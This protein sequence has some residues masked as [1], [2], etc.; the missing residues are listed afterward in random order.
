MVWVLVGIRVGVRLRVGEGKCRV[1]GRNCCR[2][3]AM[4]MGAGRFKG[5]GRVSIGVRLGVGVVLGIGR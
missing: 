4:G 1:M 2:V 5:R 3:K